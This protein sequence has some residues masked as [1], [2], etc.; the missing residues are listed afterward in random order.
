MNIRKSSSILVAGFLLS[1]D[2][3][4]A[5]LE[6]RV[7]FGHNGW[8]WV[9][10]PTRL[11]DRLR[12]AGSWGYNAFAYAV[13]APARLD[14]KGDTNW[15]RDASTGGEWRLAE[16]RRQGHADAWGG[17]VARL[18]ASQAA[19]EAEGL[20][21]IPA[22]GPW[23]WGNTVQ[24]IDPATAAG[25][26]YAIATPAASEEGFRLESGGGILASS[27]Q[28]GEAGAGGKADIRFGRD[29]RLAKA[30]IKVRGPGFHAAQFTAKPRRDGYWRLEMEVENRGGADSVMAKVYSFHGWETHPLSTRLVARAAGPLHRDSSPAALSLA[31]FAAAG[32]TLLL[33][34]EVHSR[35]RDGG[36]LRIR[37]ARLRPALPPSRLMIEP[38]A[39]APD[40][41]YGAAWD[42]LGGARGHFPDQDCDPIRRSVDPAHPATRRIFLEVARAVATASGR[43]PGRYLLGG[44]EVFC[45]R[46]RRLSRSPYAGMDRGTLYATLL[47][48]RMRAVD[49]VYARLYPRDTTQIA[50]IVWGDMLTSMH[51][52]GWG[53]LGALDVLA[54]ARLPPGKILVAP[55]YYDSHIA[56]SAVLYR[57]RGIP[58]SLPDL[59]KFRRLL[60]RDLREISGAGL[61]LLG[62]YS[63]DGRGVSAS[64]EVAG[65]EAWAGVCGEFS[66]LPA[67]RDGAVRKRKGAC[68]GLLY[69]GWDLVPTGEWGNEYNGLLSLAWFGWASRGR[70]GGAGD[71][72]ADKDGN[73]VLDALETRRPGPF[74]PSPPGRPRP[75][76]APSSPR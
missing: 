4:A 31:F 40:S 44:D 58:S 49:S 15:I 16:G 52:L 45:W 62:A 21:Y 74:S 46:S 38:A 69:A 29:G 67:T 68:R 60:R 47:L 72:F 2:L 71:L 66:A 33:D 3:P 20:E 26:Y 75:S 76:P 48:E 63:T 19:A 43:K 41:A 42:S 35:A 70:S 18:K 13:N 64:E 5:D 22:W 32:E 34:V 17:L 6:L 54:A 61:D 7:L 53:T 51:G 23:G 65:A 24:D 8:S 27:G 36:S 57:K 28:W 11:R 1:A 39:S 9:D 55:W 59:E 30:E 56:G 37:S 50:Y 14:G 73:G 25:A 12:F 10:D